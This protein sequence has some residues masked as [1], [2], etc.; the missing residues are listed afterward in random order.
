[1]SDFSLLENIPLLIFGLGFTIVFV[2]FLDGAFIL[3]FAKDFQRIQRGKR[4]LTK[5]LYGFLTIL[6]VSSI[7]LFVSWRL[8]EQRDEPIQISGEFPAAPINLNFPSPPQ[9][10][11]ISDVYFNGPISIK[12]NDNIINREAIF[13]VLC[14]QGE[15][16][17]IIYLGEAGK[18]IF[19]SGHEKAKCW[20]ENC[21]P[22]SNL[23]LAILWTAGDK[24]DFDEKEKI[25][26]SLK[27][28]F[29]FPCLDK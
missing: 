20:K 29:D 13:L 7:S 2:I 27:Q 9:F 11:E 12:D 4:T 8:N 14:K 25:K 15:E 5:S 3:L 21:E 28:E 17:D 24:Y 19:L 26:L 10:I 6:I 18:Q 23:Y 1:M 16:Y 22:S